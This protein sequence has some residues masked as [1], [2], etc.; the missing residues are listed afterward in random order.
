LKIF[1]YE[2]SYEDKKDTI[3]RKYK[4]KLQKDLLNLYYLYYLASNEEREKQPVII[5]DDYVDNLLDN[6]I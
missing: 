5:T 6:L 1:P 2:S 4:G 3:I